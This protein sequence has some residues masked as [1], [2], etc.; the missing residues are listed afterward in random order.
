MSVKRNSPWGDDIK[1]NRIVMRNKKWKWCRA[2]LSLSLSFLHWRCWPCRPTQTPPIFLHQRKISST[3]SA[4]QKPTTPTPTPTPPLPLR[5]SGLSVINGEGILS[6]RRQC[7]RR[8]HLRFLLFAW[9]AFPIKWGTFW[10]R[11]SF[12]GCER[13][14]R[15]FADKFRPMCHLRGKKIT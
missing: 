5:P 3:S 14:V 13:T 9:F 8:R 15:S 7:R 4:L 10:E 2:S 12:E 11:G 1:F 6:R